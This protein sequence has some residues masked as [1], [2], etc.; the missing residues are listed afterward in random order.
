VKG[1]LKH[2]L[3]KILSIVLASMLLASTAVIIA[4]ETTPPANRPAASEVQRRGPQQSPMWLALD[5]NKDGT[6]DASEIAKASVSLKTLDVNKDGKVTAD[7]C[8][9][10]GMGM[11]RGQGGQGRGFGGPRTQ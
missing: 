10:Q 5:L 11:G 6:L 7:E 9:P 3:M 1:Y 4:Q 8:R 2:K